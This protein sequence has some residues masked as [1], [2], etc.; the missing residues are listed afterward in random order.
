[1]KEYRNC[2]N[3]QQASKRELQ[4]SSALLGNRFFFKQSLK[5]RLMNFVITSKVHNNFM[6]R[7]LTPLA[8]SSCLCL[9]AFAEDSARL[10]EDLCL[11]AK[12]DKEIKDDLPFFYNFSLVG[13]YF[14]MPSARMKSAGEFAIGGGYVPPY[15]VFGANFQPFDHLELS[16]NYRIYNGITEANFGNE[17]FGDDAERIGNI[18]FALLLPEDG[19][20]LFP[21]I[22]IGLD[23]FIGTK[24]FSA[25]YIVATQ[26]LLDYNLELSL[27]WGR[28]R[29]KGLFGGVAWTPLRKS[30]IFLLKDISL[31]AEYDAIDYKQHPHEH[32][33]GR[34]VS[35]RING[36][37]SCVLGDVLQ[38][39]VSSVRGKEIAGYGS[40]R[41]P[42]GTTSGFLP[43]VDDPSLYTSPVD[44]EPLGVIRHD[45]VFAQELAYA[46]SDQGLDLYRAVLKRDENGC[47]E[48][49]I[50]VVNNRYREEQE[51]RCRLEH[52]LAA[53]MP[54]DISSIIAVIE[55]DALPSH[56][57]R[58]D[59]R[60][61][62]QYQAGWL[63]TF[64]LETIAPMREAVRAPSGKEATLL[65]QRKKGIWS[66]TFR[67]RLLSFFGSAEGKFKY[68]FGVVGTQEGYLWDE[69]FYR[70]QVSYAIKSSMAGLGAQDRLNP[71]H[72]VNVRTDSLLY[73][74]SNTVSLEEAFV[75]KDWNLGK[76][77]FYRLATGYF[78]PAYGG[79]ATEV[80]YYPAG[81]D[82]AIGV[83]T[84][85][86]LKRRYEG[87]A[88]T[89][90]IRKLKGHTVEHVPF[91]GVQYF[92][93]LYYR[94][95]PL[96]LEFKMNIGQFLAKDKGARLEVGR[97][98]KSGFKMSV[99]TAVTNGHDRVNGRPYY[100]KG[101]ALTFPFDMF[102]KQSSRN[103]V[104]YAM[105]AWLRDVGAI[106]GNGKPLYYTLNQER[107]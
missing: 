90:K 28:K 7:L 61:L 102:L 30:E 14:N 84:A 25:E 15:T 91:L 10:F 35:S 47:K 60:I 74:K 2:G 82:W 36:G 31:L 100:D 51:V 98:F 62:Q 72:L 46:L 16:A 66:F 55:V 80:L 79:G 63:D 68:N 85:V 97:Y 54:S 104:T 27:G 9:S 34:Q 89:H 58:F 69:V 53:L 19:F 37:I 93:D 18:K 103:Y 65:Y 32:P 40:L 99:W 38:L 29:I 17:G 24:R 23:D 70:L 43:K 76:G 77:W 5:S 95:R 39:S 101:F 87:I 78:E 20:P 22:A 67:P 49:W 6:K 57:Y 42:I 64:E 86:I 81:S 75:Q 83:E 4:N 59:G 8:L 11:V 44:T 52:V 71:S 26:K 106:S 12:I 1:M 107:R 3:Y 13:G 105:S 94:F 45:K 73:Y 21:S 33:S 96:Q 41:C 92:L 48:L 56:S 88:F 50:K